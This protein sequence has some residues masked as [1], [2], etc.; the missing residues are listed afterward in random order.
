MSDDLVMYMYMYM[1]MQLMQTDKKENNLINLILR[2][3]T[4]HFVLSLIDEKLNELRRFIDT[5]N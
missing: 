1:Y 3:Y 4:A 2:F 5:V